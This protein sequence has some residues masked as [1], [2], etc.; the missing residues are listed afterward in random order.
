[1]FKYFKSMVEPSFLLFNYGASLFVDQPYKYIFAG[2]FIFQLFFF[3][4]KLFKSHDNAF[5]LKL[6]QFV[7]GL[8]GTSEQVL[9]SCDQVQAATEDQASAIVETGTASNEIS[10]MVTRNT[11]NIAQVSASVKEIDNIIE[12]S[13][14]ATDKLVQNFQLFESQNESVMDLL[15][16]TSQMLSDLTGQFNE[17]VTKTSMINDIVFQ[18]KLLSFNASVEAARAGEHGKGFSVVAEEIGNLANMSGESALSIQTTLETTDKKV[19]S[20]L[21]DIEVGA[22][23]LKEAIKSQQK[24][25]GII[26]NDFRNQFG[27]VE[28]RVSTIVEQVKDI[29]VAS[30][31]QAKGVEELRDAIHLVNETVQRNI[32]VIGQ[33]SNL[34][35]VL[36]D[37]VDSFQDDFVAYENAVG[38]SN[39]FIEPI[40]WDQKYAIGI[41]QMDEEHIEILKR[42]NDLI[43]A[44]NLNVLDKM[45]SSFTELKE[46]TVH[47][48]T[49]EEKYMEQIQYP[50][51][52]S[53]KKVHVNLI[54]TLLKFEEQFKAGKIEKGRLASFLKNWLFTHIMGIDTKYA[55]HAKEHNSLNNA[56]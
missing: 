44:M 25:S 53:H 26:L 17:V 8:M 5:N 19:K 46:Y 55:N 12:A 9:S 24:Q 42:I 52:D 49:H 47:H 6:K 38:V 30:V 45:L 27:Q 23:Q 40:L 31:E 1:M 4:R 20:I 34:A 56:A 33:T 21:N 7:S 29:E 36:S 14:K 15:D 48:F 10:S 18:T 2:V 32:L 37:S 51:L 50:A 43:E 35:H 54:N 39:L 11:E 41:H 28:S 3:T 13:V 22:S 16:G